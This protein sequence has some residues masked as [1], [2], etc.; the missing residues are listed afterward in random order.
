[1]ITV[2]PV[3]DYEGHNDRGLLQVN[4]FVQFYAVLPPSSL[5]QNN[6]ASKKPPNSPKTSPLAKSNMGNFPLLAVNSAPVLPMAEQHQ[7]RINAPLLREDARAMSLW[8]HSRLI[9]STA[10]IA[11]PNSRSCTMY[12]TRIRPRPSQ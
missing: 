6:A 1:M 10:L 2:N 12:V 4:D 9:F 5:V 11:P 7:A 8:Q 3:I